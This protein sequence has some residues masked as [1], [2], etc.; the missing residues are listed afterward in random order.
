MTDHLSGWFN[1]VIV[2][3]LDTSVFKVSYNVLYQRWVAAMLKMK[4]KPSGKY[5]TGYISHK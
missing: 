4:E 2:I 1:A 5:S 3:K